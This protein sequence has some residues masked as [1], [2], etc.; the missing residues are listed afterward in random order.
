MNKREITQVPR[1]MKPGRRELNEA[2]LRVSMSLAVPAHMKDRV[3]EITHVYVEPSARRKRLATGLLNFVCQEADANGI[4]LLLTARPQIQ[5][6]DAKGNL[7]PVDGPT[8]D[9]LVH[10]YTKFGFTAIQETPHGPIMARKVFEKPKVLQPSRS[11]HQAVRQV[12]Q[13]RMH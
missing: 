5:V 13:S 3:R 6:V 11:L 12:L 1:G 10:W 7:K 8:E 4:T 2:S 9:E